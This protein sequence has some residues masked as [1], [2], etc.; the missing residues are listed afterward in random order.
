MKEVTKSFKYRIYPNKEQ[1]QKI[2]N[3]F[4]CCRFV[5]NYY[6]DK[7][8]NL[9]KENKETFNYYKCANDLTLLKSELL[10]LKDCDATAYQH[11]LKN[12]ESAYKN[13]F[14]K[15]GKFPKFKSKKSSKQSYT[16]TN[17]SNSIA[18]L[19]NGIKLPKLGIVKSKNNLPISGKILSATVSK[20]SSGKYFVSLNCKNSLIEGYDK[21]GS[22]IGIDLGIKDFL[23]TSN[24]DKVENPKCFQKAHRK[25]AKLQRKLSRKPI[26][27]NNRHKARIL[28]SR[29]HEK[30]VNQR[31]DFLQK[32][33]TN[34]IKENDIICIEDL[35]VKNMI[36]NHKLAKNISD[37]S[38][39]EFVRMLSYKAEWYNRK[40]IKIDR[41]FPSSQI[42]S[43]C[44]YKN[45]EVRNLSIREWLCPSCNTK[46]DRDIN[47]A[48]NILNEGLLSI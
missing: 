35:S 31:N 40:I 11:S 41:F 21:T 30:I 29:L 13:F 12:L 17:N 8:I 28:V 25:L 10:W 42:C 19:G 18:Y 5:Y 1:Q 32:L 27:S 48:T 26:G 34:L 24:G 45:M 39:S 38:W 47:A 9:Y 20:T 37:A 7:R 46:H 16:S 44:G 4:G 23:I 22:A 6:L 43:N 36:K 2:E 14:S 33:S 3:M 15:N